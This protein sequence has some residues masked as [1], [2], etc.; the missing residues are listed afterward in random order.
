MR[1]VRTEYLNPSTGNVYTG[2]TGHGESMADLETYLFPLTGV[3]LRET[4]GSGVAQGLEVSADVGQPGLTVKSGLAIDGEGRPIVLS[5]DG[6]AVVDPNAPPAPQVQNV[7]LVLVGSGGVQVPT[8]G[9]TGAQV[10]TVTAR[11]AEDAASR[12][13]VHAPWLRLVDQATFTDDGTS[14]PLALVTLNATGAVSALGAGPRRQVSP[15]VGRLTLGRTS[16][17]SGQTRS[18]GAVAGPSLQSRQDGGLDVVLPGSQAAAALSVEGSAGNVLAR[19]NVGIGTA[20]PTAG[21]EVD[22][23]S[24]AALGVKLS[25]SGP[26]WGAGLQLSNRAGGSGRTYG[27]YAGDDGRWHFVDVT[28]GQDRLVVDAA[29]RVGIGTGSDPVAKPLHVVGGVHS[30]G[31]EAG[32]SFGDRQ[33][34]GYVDA[35]SKGERWVWYAEG[36]Y[37][38]LWSGGDALSVGEP[39]DGGGLDVPRRM[40]V[41]QGPDASAGIWFWQNG[42]PGAALVGMSDDT[43]VGLWGQGVAWG[44]TM[45][46]Q[47]GAVSTAAGVTVGAGGPADLSVSGGVTVGAGGNA[48]LTT[49][50]VDGKMDGSDGPDDLHLNWATG[51][52][53]HIGG[54]AAAALAV[55]GSAVVD[56]SL[57]AASVSDSFHTTNGQSWLR[58]QVYTGELFGHWDG[59]ATVRLF[60]SSLYDLGDN[61]LQI[62]SGG[63]RTFMRGDVT[64]EGMSWLKGQV[65]TG[66]LFGHWDGKATMR[67]FGSVLWDA[68]DGWLQL[69]SGGG[70]TFLRGEVTVQ[71]ALHKAGGGFRIDH[72]LAPGEKYLSHSFV[73]SPEM[74]N[75]YNGVAVTDENGQAQV[76]LPDYFEVLNRD[77]RFQLTTMGQLAM[78]TVEGEVRD[79]AFIIRTDKP[80]VTVSW[81]VT[82]V[83]QDSWAEAHR[84]TVEE[85]KPGEENG[86]FLH[87]ELFGQ[88]ADRAFLGAAPS[89]PGDHAAAPALQSPP[90]PPQSEPPQPE[91]PTG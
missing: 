18:V 57:A 65:Y 83:R 25:A 44:L 63:G 89:E 2:P 5:E 85:D 21:L 20:A 54:G 71:G 80:G 47:S 61:W 19:G 66:E 3:L 6:A 10:L 43:H 8:S 41:R 82:G 38:R 14:V 91:G 9:L 28:Q 27:T 62:Q 70:K 32:L 46:V 22:R 11:E 68:G 24:A 48:V 60:G 59:R 16:V 79:N 56:G 35:P 49:R 36:G 74:V 58:G 55:H 45:D 53:V 26:G 87:P 40:R 88:Q 67:L 39:G 84:I 78:A 31:P 75:L 13:L 72:P 12:T 34:A 29:G 30:G 7:P 64:V 37:A 77:H 33:V 81:Q 17:A 50:H 86:S 51:R 69:Q 90:D 23:G 4:F 73:E 15:T 52:T 76:S 1:L 42:A